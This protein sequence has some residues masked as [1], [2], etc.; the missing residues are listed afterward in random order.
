MFFIYFIL[1]KVLSC[2]IKPCSP[3][4]IYHNHE[5]LGPV[6]TQICNEMGFFL[7]ISLFHAKLNN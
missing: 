3:K 7:R 5:S 4:K 2:E 6:I 1:L